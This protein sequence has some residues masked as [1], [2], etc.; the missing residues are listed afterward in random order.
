MADH[1]PLIASF[2]QRVFVEPNVRVMAQSALVEALEDTLFG[3]RE[4]LGEQAFPKGASEYLN[5]W[6]AP[7]RGW[8]RKF[9]PPASDEV[10]F[11]L[12]PATER[13][14]SWLGGLTD[15]AFVGTESR[16]LTL[17]DLL[18]Q[19]KQG[20]ETD[21]QARVA[22]LHKRRDAIDDEIA[23][24]LSGDLPLLDD[25]ALRERFMHF[26]SLARELLTDFREVEHNFRALDRSVRER[27][28]LWQGAKGALLQA[29]LGERDAI[30]DSDQGKSFKAFWDFLMSQ[31]RQEELT[32][33]L[34][35]VMAL[36]PVAELHP[37]PRLKRVHYDW[38]DAGE[39]AQA[40]VALLSQQLRRFLDDQAWLE[41]RRIMDLVR[42]LEAR[43][44]AVRAQPPAG[45]FMR[46]DELA[47]SIT[48]PMERPLY[49]PP[50]KL[51]LDK[52]TLLAGDGDLDTSALFDQVRVD[53]ALLSGLV[54]QML[55]QRAQ[56]TLSEVLSAHPLQQGLGELVAYL[57]L[58]SESPQAVVDDT[59]LEVVQW[60]NASGTRQ[61]HLPRVIFV[62]E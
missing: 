44:L 56:V 34:E 14:L 9:Y 2:L 1:A 6:A 32:S 62:R 59:V 4:Q 58:A 5:D 25:T 16:L 31:Q 45:D 36:P 33:L 12:T 55:Q 11:D 61:A 40:T 38:L 3:L 10:H 46:I 24:V 21:P 47:P 37:D 57:Q 29:I 22:E 30:A 42:A 51:V 39:H 54:R 43:A 48:L 23:R 52:L 13:A 27:I 53:K 41:N 50:A 20:S 49:N 17:F 7:E 35:Q 60:R 15:R 28:A 26:T 8:L 18:Q 19:M